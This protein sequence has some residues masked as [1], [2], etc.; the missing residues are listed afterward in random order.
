MAP[1][2]SFRG[3]ATLGA[4]DE[5]CGVGATFSWGSYWGYTQIASIILHL[6]N[7]IYDLIIFGQESDRG[8]DQ[9]RHSHDYLLMGILTW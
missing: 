2:V 5:G 7:I 9:I 6:V 1:K 3:G 8:F 4:I